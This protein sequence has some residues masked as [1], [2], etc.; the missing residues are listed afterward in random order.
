MQS[1]H[2]LDRLAVTFDDERLVADA[3][4]VLPATLA[5]HLGLRE[6]FDDHVD[7]GDAAGHANV[8]HKAMTLIH[9]ALAGGDSIDDAD[10]LRA[11]STQAVLGHAVLAPSTLGTF[12][13]SFTWGHARQL[14]K[15]AGELLARAWAAGAGPG[16]APVTIDV[17]SSV[18][19]TYGL[20][21]QG[22]TKFTYNHVRG[23]HPLFAVVAGTADVAHARLRGGNANSGRGA[24][25]FL[26][27]TF[28]R[29]RAAS[30]TGPITLRADS[31][32]YSGTV[33]ASCRKAGVRYSITVK[34]NKALH[35]AIAAIP[36]D[37]WV[38]IPYF[39]EGG[40]Q[41]AETTYRP[42][43]KKA[44]VVRLIVR[45]VRPTPG[46]QLA[47]LVDWSHHAF[48]TDRHG[49][50]IELEADH[51]RHAEVEN[52][53]RDLKYGVGLNH[54]PSGRFGANAAWL[55][56]NVMAHNLARFTSRIG[57]GE[58][59]VATDTLRR[60]YLRTPGRLSFSARRFTLHLPSRWPWGERFDAALAN[61]RAVT[62]VT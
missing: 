24:A 2:S 31:G 25:G 19:E 61:L 21:K 32:F 54:M 33:A 28:N 22:G 35:T 51:R 53:I 60:R 36:D 11:G 30:A 59:L 27:E 43:G 56:L 58:R 5:Q 34:L 23:Y 46:S 13:R 52:T 47:L 6:L 42:F 9:S 48:V 40:A 39:L 45:R 8:G 44:P 18:C 17:D 12:L 29:V 16:D 37:A 10:A 15:V 50:T 38:E 14:D 1:S 41:V 62:L 4:L 20:A 26:T 57:V 55:A 7:L 3:G 49:P